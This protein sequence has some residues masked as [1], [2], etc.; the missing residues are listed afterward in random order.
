MNLK[1]LR[2]KLNTDQVAITDF[3]K[4]SVQCMSKY[5]REMMNTSNPRRRKHVSLTAFVYSINYTP[6]AN[7]DVLLSDLS[8]LRIALYTMVTN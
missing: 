7:N 1:K 2:S 5:G 8:R 3:E 4:H 6:M